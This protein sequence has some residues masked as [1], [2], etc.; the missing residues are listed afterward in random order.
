MGGEECQITDGE[1]ERMKNGY[2]GLLQ[3]ARGY[4]E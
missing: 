4:E 1:R 2:D 3:V